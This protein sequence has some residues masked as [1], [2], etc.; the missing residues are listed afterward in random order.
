M[1]TKA[2]DIFDASIEY[3]AD[4]WDWSTG[5]NPPAAVLSEGALNNYYGY[6][7]FGNK[8]GGGLALLGSVGS[9]RENIDY[10]LD[11]YLDGSPSIYDIYD[12]QNAASAF[13]ANKYF[14]VMNSAGTN[15]K[16]AL[17]LRP[18]AKNLT[19]ANNQLISPPANQF[20]VDVQRGKFLFPRPIFWSNLSSTSSWVYPIIQ[21]GNSMPTTILTGSNFPLGGT[22]IFDFQPGKYGYAYRHYH[23]GWGDSYSTLKPFT[24]SQ[25]LGKGTLT[26]WFYLTQGSWSNSMLYVY[27]NASTYIG[28][29]ADINFIWA[30]Q[31][32]AYN[33]N[34][35]GEVSITAGNFRN[36][37][38]HLAVTW[39]SATDTGA[40][41]TITVYIDN[42]AVMSLSGLNF[43][44]NDLQIRTLQNHSL[45]QTDAVVYVDNVKVWNHVLSAPGAE[46]TG[47][48]EN[49]LHPTFVNLWYPRVGYYKR[50][51]L[52]TAAW[53]LRPPTAAPNAQ[54]QLEAANNFQYAEGYIGFKEVLKDAAYAGVLAGT[55]YQYGKRLDA[56]VA[57]DPNN[58]FDRLDEGDP[59]GGIYDTAASGPL[60]ASPNN[61]FFRIVD[62]AKNIRFSG[63]GGLGLAVYA[64]DLS[65]TNI[66]PP[67]T[68]CYVDPN[69]GRFVLPRPNYFCKCD[70]VAELS[71]PTLRDVE[72]PFV[73]GIT[74]DNFSIVAGKTEFGGYGIQTTGA[75]TNVGYVYPF[76]YSNQ[77][78]FV[79]QS[80]T[81]STTIVFAGEQT[82]LPG[83]I[84]TVMVGNTTAVRG[85]TSF[86][87]GGTGTSFTVDNL[88]EMT[89]GD[90]VIVGN[91]LSQGTMSFWIQIE[92]AT[93][94]TAAFI[95][96]LGGTN[97]FIYFDETHMDI[98]IN[99][100]PVVERL[101]LSNFSVSLG[102]T[103]HHVYVMWDQTGS[104]HANTERI[105][106]WIDGTEITWAATIP[107]WA[108][109]DFAFK[110]HVI[111]DSV[112]IDNIKIFKHLVVEA[113]T[114][115]Y[116]AGAG[117]ENAMHYMYGSDHNYAPD[118]TT[119]DSG[120]GYYKSA[121][122]TDIA[123]WT[124]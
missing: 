84:V 3:N 89:I 33:I 46:Y 51:V 90:V 74:E 104:L 50:G 21:Y 24:L 48:D 101:A 43:N 95:I 14:R 102:T 64:A 87:T 2:L 18:V 40:S 80:G 67:K 62:N 73:T 54:I 57:E 81:N 122:L 20:Y 55:H 15:V 32:Y 83:E 5:S 68:Q 115:E 71:N 117:R 7:T 17:G 86:T 113:P 1:R 121:G 110:F 123:V 96:Y 77:Q 39:S 47:N 11:D 116:N 107:V 37:W 22:A 52:E 65:T 29:I 91:K 111:N 30:R 85:I 56:S 79:A 34:G 23:N 6:G 31:R 35:A 58:G 25:N 61:K 28:I 108:A 63:A 94:S 75:Y 19:L 8:S 93:N 114:W 72:T 124:V 16:S 112:T 98:Y 99:S 12:T 59:S 36:A 53:Q 4:A 103:F 119:A 97:S 27:F 38:H 26:C 100:L 78:S 60:S 70:S 105:R 82:F 13:A 45:I 10:R 88:D 9:L 42:V 109:G 44:V 106:I 120:V 41:T 66:T 69:R 49:F 92:E 118:C 76:G